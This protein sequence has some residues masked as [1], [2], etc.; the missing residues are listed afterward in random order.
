LQHKTNPMAEQAKAA[1]SPLTVK[2]GCKVNLSLDITG[3]R[4]DGYH[5]LETLFYPLPEPCDTITMR[6][7]APG[8]GLSITSNVP[9]LDLDSNTMAKAWRAFG[10]ATGLFPDMRIELEKNIPMGAG[11]GGGSS[12]AAVVLAQLNRLAGG[13]ALSEDA[14]NRLAASVGADVPFFLVNRPA[15]AIGV[16]DQLTPADV[17]LSGMH[18]VLACPGVHVSTAWAYGAWDAIHGQSPRDGLTWRQSDIRKVNSSRV[19]LANAF[20]E[21]VFQNYP[22]IRKLKES[23]LASGACGAVMSGS[24]SSVFA[25]FRDPGVAQE[26]ARIEA[27][28][29]AV[30]HLL[31]L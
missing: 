1:F 11:L 21:V 7:S 2:A 8:S 3:I 6:P 13:R 12:D 27:G 31:A 25:L 23:L 4:E 9:G 19:C 30:V 28:R 20:E 26:A 14:L 18:A 5:E 24:G 10:D 17:S 22:T 29:Q 16:G 15:W